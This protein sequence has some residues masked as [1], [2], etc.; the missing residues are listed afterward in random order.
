MAGGDLGDMFHPSSEAPIVHCL[1]LQVNVVDHRKWFSNFVQHVTWLNSWLYLRTKINCTQLVRKH[2]NYCV[3]TL[4]STRVNL[5]LSVL[6]LCLQSTWTSRAHVYLYCTSLDT[7]VYTQV[8][9]TTLPQIHL[10]IPHIPLQV[11]APP[12][13]QSF[14][15][16]FTPD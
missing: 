5:Y 6:H 8:P 7:R 16:D 1:E 10:H 15:T 9:R 4:C 12:P 14:H 11:P 13:I 3:H 2:L